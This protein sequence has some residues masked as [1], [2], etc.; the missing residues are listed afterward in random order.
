[1]KWISWIVVVVVCVAVA[2]GL[3]WFKYAEI[4]AAIAQGEAF[5]EPV[6]AVEVYVTK[7][8]QRQPSLAVTGEVVARRSAQ[9]RN[10][11]KG[12]IASVGFDPGAEVKKGQL[13]VQ[14]SVEQEKAQRAEAVADQEIARLALN[15]AERLVKRGAGSV[16]NRDQARAQFAA[17]GAR[18]AALDALIAKKSL[19]APFDAI[20]G[21]HQLQVGQFLDAASMIVELVGVGEHA[22]IDFSLPQDRAYIPIGSTVEIS[23]SQSGD[24]FAA[25]V[26]ARDAMVNT[27]SRSLTVRAQVPGRNHGLVPG[28]LVRVNVPLAEATQVVV[29]PPTAIRRDAFGPSVYVIEDVQENGVAKLR[30]RKRAVALSAIADV[31]QSQDWVVVAKGLTEGEQIA[32]LGAFKLFDGA[33][34]AVAQP[35]MDASDRLVGH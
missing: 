28:M 29:V 2:A 22:W 34:I 16:E 17:A 20:A 3:G 15:R 5:P 1:M 19:R 23:A 25:Q 9:L 24:K 12:R 13:L 11:L 33:L 21:L 7:S 32:A 27:R 10:E 14:L 30:A 6:Q 31:D 4:Q 35:S 18:V 26:I 8:I